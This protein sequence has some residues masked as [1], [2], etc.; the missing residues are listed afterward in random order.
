MADHLN[1][2]VESEP[3]P[4]F[5]LRQ[6]LVFG[7]ARSR[8]WIATTAAV[9]LAIGM[10][11]A[12]LQPNTY[13]SEA[14][15]FLRVG[16]REQVTFD[17]LMGTLEE[18]SSRGPTI[19]DE[20]HMLSDRSIYGRVAQ[21]LGPG[22]ILRPADPSRYDDDETPLLLRAMHEVQAFLYGFGSAIGVSGEGQEAM[23][24]ATEILHRNT[25]LVTDEESSVITVL[26]T[27][28]AP[29]RARDYNQAIVE[30][31]VE[32]HAEQFSID[33]YLE[34]NRHKL[35]EAERKRDELD[36]AY[37]DLLEGCG[38]YDFETQRPALIEEL[39]DQQGELHIARTLRSETKAQR[40]ALGLRMSG[41]P[42][43]LTVVGSPQ[44]NPRYLELS[45]AVDEL[46]VTL[47]GLDARIESLEGW[48]ATKR[49]E[50]DRLRECEK[51]HA[52][53]AT[54]R[55]AANE[56]YS[57]L[58]RRYDMLEG[59]AGLREETSNLRV[60]QAPDLDDK[61]VGPARGKILLVGLLGGT[62]VGVFAALVRE[63]LDRRLRY[64]HAIERTLGVRVLDVIPDVGD[65][66]GD[67][68]RHAA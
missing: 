42:R 23:R 5:D 54:V 51:Q 25:E 43:E 4:R 1:D 64:P 19:S 24:A 61:K 37:F 26:H 14:K 60:M 41:V 50:L 44:P 8:R 55:T 58:M 13:T 31:F 57:T 28:N 46:D 38:F 62:A 32:R 45:E 67:D 6:L 33:R 48:V 22:E 65:L 36:K 52:Y 68:E 21:K 63:L 39:E 16:Q 2:L 30:A 11:S 7:V 10:G 56:R 27:S 17:T 34:E 12:M 40:E 35:D 9:G 29:E 47:A 15:L 59:L 49:A 18:P 66:D 3:G 20:V 53:L